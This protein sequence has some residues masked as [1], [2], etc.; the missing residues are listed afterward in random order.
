[1]IKR[2]INKVKE[3]GVK[4][5]SHLICTK[6]IKVLKINFLNVINAFGIRRQMEKLAEENAGLPLIVFSPIVDWNIPLFQRPQHIALSLARTGYL[7]VFCTI[8][9]YDAVSGFQKSGGVETLY[10]SNQY[11]KALKM[12]E[13]FKE[14]YV[15]I[16]AQD[17]KVK[18]KDIEELI[19]RGFTII[20]EYI[21]ELT[22]ELYCS[23]EEVLDRHL[24]VLKDERCHVICTST[25]LYDE[26]SR[27]RN[28]NVALITNGVD[29]E[30]FSRNFGQEDIPGAISHLVH[31]KKPVI[32]YFGALA[33]WF[34]YDL[35][36]KVAKERPEYELLIL[37]WSYDGSLNRS[38]LRAYENV[39]ILGPINYKDL[40]KYSSSFDIS[41]IPFRINDITKSTSPVKLFEYMAAGNPIVTTD[42]P[43]CRKYNS[44][45]IGKDHDEFL[46][47][48][49]EALNLK[50]D[51]E[52]KKMLALEAQA[53]TWT[54]KAKE[55][56]T[57]IK[58][59]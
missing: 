36:E 44:V 20:Y 42:L 10:L 25:K 23:K 38:N 8:N 29:Y 57:L 58:S 2:I 46:K 40:P 24:R 28:H 4:H 48:L 49:D 54:K 6:L 34:D 50:N 14:K 52:Y 7:Y 17:V 1:M 59:H 5:T 51:L 3:H 16:Y 53:N 41:I 19:S 30:H 55:I 22:E 45:L 15:H 9:N 26:V 33:N 35:I 12:G 47:L 13:R 18:A 56:D 32:G 31:K 39:T 21:D 11:Q 43:E 27:Y 37:G